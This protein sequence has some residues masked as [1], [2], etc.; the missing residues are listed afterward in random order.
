VAFD[1]TACGGLLKH[2]A[3]LGHEKRDVA[4]HRLT[5]IDAEIRSAA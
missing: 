3:R 1:L 2:V 4:S 5:A